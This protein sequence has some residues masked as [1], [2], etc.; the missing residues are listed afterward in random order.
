VGGAPPPPA[1]GGG[2]GGGGGGGAGRAIAGEG[3]GGKTHNCQGR[4]MA[5]PYKRGGGG[6]KEDNHVKN[7]EEDKHCMRTLQCNA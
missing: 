5:Q 3:K 2:G 4:Y 6:Y 7:T 1:P